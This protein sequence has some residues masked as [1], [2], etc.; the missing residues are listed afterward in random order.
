MELFTC[1]QNLYTQTLAHIYTF[2][3]KILIMNLA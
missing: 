1:A 2:Y 3:N